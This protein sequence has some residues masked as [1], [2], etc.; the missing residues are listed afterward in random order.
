[1]TTGPVGKRPTRPHFW[2][3]ALLAPMFLVLASCASADSSEVASIR[4]AAV[5]PSESGGS[6]TTQDDGLAFAQCMR[7]NGLEFPDPDPDGGFGFGNGQPPSFDRNSP[8]FQ[9]AIEACQELRPRGGRGDRT[10]DAAAQEAAIGLAGCMREKGRDFPDPQFDANG[11]RVGGNSFGRQ[12][13][14]DPNFREDI[15]TCRQESGLEI[16]GPGGRGGPGGPA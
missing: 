3:L 6:S 14:S 7:E 8:D 1:V 15:Q 5:A 2:V 9:A 11:S 16:G 12:G 10:F 13:A 4:D